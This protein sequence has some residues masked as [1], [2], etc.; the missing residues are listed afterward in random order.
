MVALHCLVS[1][2]VIAL[3]GVL[4]FAF[5][6]P[7]ELRHL[8]GGL[9]LF[10]VVA[11]VDAVCG[12]LLTM[13]LYRT[14]KSRQELAADL[15]LVA[16]IQLVA[17]AYGL[18]ALAQARPLAQVF[19]TDRFR[20]VS[21]ADIAE[22]DAEHLPAWF[23]PWGLASVRTLGLRP[24]TSAS[25]RLESLSA[26]LQGFDAGQRP[27]R[28]Q[29]YALNRKEVL[30]RSGTMAE[31]Q[32]MHVERPQVVDQAISAALQNAQPGETE[33]AD[34]LR[35]LPIVSRNG[36]D[37]VVLLDPATLRIRS[38]APLDGFR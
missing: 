23:K 38:Y 24:I 18:H 5:W 8:T 20:L 26:A 13:V 31:L 6:F 17:L 15:I 11:G 27:Q 4:V 25:E 28:W 30:E 19:E 36:A 14:S 16:L 22:N 29:D 35:W 3:V 7:A 37:G 1:I 2:T 33:E 9:K 10:S 32:E 21:Y 34:E 12:P